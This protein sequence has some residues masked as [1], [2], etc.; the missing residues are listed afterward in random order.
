MPNKCV[1][2]ELT[3]TSNAHL[4]KIRNRTGDIKGLRHMRGTSES[5]DI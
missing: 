5:E 4:R 2:D 3:D 1:L